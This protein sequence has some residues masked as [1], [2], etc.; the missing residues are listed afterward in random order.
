ML[1]SSLYSGFASASDYYYRAAAARVLESIAVPTLVIHAQDDPFIL[2]TP[3]S[4][5]KL[6]ANPNI[7][8]VETAH[9]GHCAFLD[10]PD[11]ATGYD[12]YWAEGTL[13]RFLMAEV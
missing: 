4:A 1:L 12:G 10:A 6:E 3:E 8:L 9:G 13:L 11:K 7:T 5:A 2:I